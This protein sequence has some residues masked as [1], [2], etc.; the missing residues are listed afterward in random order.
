ME[1][2]GFKRMLFTEIIQIK[3][4]QY[5]YL[6]SVIKNAAFARH[7]QAGGSRYIHSPLSPYE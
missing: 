5:N 3:K 7:T 6:L 2:S 4:T 1:Q